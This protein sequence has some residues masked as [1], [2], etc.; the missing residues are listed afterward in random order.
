VTATRTR[1]S[2]P[3]EAPL[4]AAPEAPDRLQA[5]SARLRSRRS[6][7][8]DRGFQLAGAAL[9]G[10]GLLAIV[11]GWYGV[12]HTARQWR[13]TPY[14][15]SG[16]VLGLALVFIGG[17]AYFSY[18]LTRLVEQGQRQTAVLERIE[19]ALTGGPALDDAALVVAPPGILHRAS[20]PLLL[21]RHDLH[22]L[23]EAD[24]VLRACP[25]CEPPL[26]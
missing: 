14:V 20:C 19:A 22:A 26:P 13:Q 3:L 18:W 17:F 11:A 21:G 2:A 25:V 23:G 12:S 16:G 6:L 8:I 10:I 5:A 1:R 7:P 24:E 15:V 9:L 4:E